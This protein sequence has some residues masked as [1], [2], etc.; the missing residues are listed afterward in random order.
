LAVFAGYGLAK[1]TIL[2]F[3]IILSGSAKHHQIHQT[4][5][6]TSRVGMHFLALENEAFVDVEARPGW[7]SQSDLIFPW[8]VDGANSVN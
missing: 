2:I 5:N 7:R 4:R 3:S 1:I 6:D 8:N